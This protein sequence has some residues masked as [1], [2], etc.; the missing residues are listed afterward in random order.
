MDTC[1]ECCQYS[2][3]FDPYVKVAQ[4][5]RLECG[6]GESMSNSDYQL[7][8]QSKDRAKD[9][10]WHINWGDGD[11]S[12]IIAPDEKTAIERIP[13]G[14]GYANFIVRLDSVYQQIFKAGRKEVVEWINNHSSKVESVYAVLSGQNAAEFN[15]SH[16]K[17]KLKEWGIEN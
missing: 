10:L 8:F 7:K 14:V 12:F 11:N 13:E 3:V 17:S 4:C 2:L 16:W 5:L 1:P 6:Y 15:V 9:T